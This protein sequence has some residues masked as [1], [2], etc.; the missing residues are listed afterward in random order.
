MVAAAT[1]AGPPLGLAAA[2]DHRRHVLR[3][4]FRRRLAHAAAGLPAVALIGRFGLDGIM[5]KPALV[6]SS[7]PHETAAHFRAASKA[8]DLPVMSCNNPPI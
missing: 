7:K 1:P 5:V 3:A 6:Y 2:S 4:A 8:T